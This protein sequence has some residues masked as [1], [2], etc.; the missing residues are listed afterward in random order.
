MKWGK[1]ERLRA[2][3]ELLEVAWSSLLD[4]KQYLVDKKDW[5]EIIKR[6]AFDLDRILDEIKYY[7]RGKEEDK[8]N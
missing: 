3:G 6:S 2:G 5:Y 4:A 8:K 1:L 7:V